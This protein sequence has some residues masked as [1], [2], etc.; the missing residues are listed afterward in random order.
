MDGIYERGQVYHEFF[1]ETNQ[2]KAKE[3]LRPKELWSKVWSS[4]RPGAERVLLQWHVFSF[5]MRVHW[6]REALRA[7]YLV[8]APQHDGELGQRTRSRVI[9]KFPPD[10]SHT[11]T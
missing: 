8:I 4:K 7:A 11:W 2:A 10:V 5:F 1:D 3:M 6:L 9:M